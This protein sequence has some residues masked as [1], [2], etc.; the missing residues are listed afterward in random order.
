M[1]VRNTF[2]IFL[3]SGFWHGANWTFIAWGFLNALYFIP[4]LLLDKNRNYL[5]VIPTHNFFPSL[6]EF[7][8]I[9]FT[10]F[11]TVIAWVFFR[12]N[13]I[14]QAFEI[15]KEIFSTRFFQTPTFLKGTD[16]IYFI[17]H[18]SM[19]ALLLF[20]EWIHR[21]KQFGLQF[22]ESTMNS[23]VKRWA[24]YGILVVL[25]LLF[26]GKQNNFIYFQF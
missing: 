9:L 23:M 12:A 8:Q 13:T 19:I 5:H 14:T 21:D 17:I 2:I 16:M 25:I 10:F 4:L 11:L 7:F 18:C 15:L 26:G 3:V 6:K 22:N 24:I 20:V 1:K